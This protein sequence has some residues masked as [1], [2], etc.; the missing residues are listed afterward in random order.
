MQALLSPPLTLG[1]YRGLV[2]A[3]DPDALLV[4][5]RLLRRAAE[6]E[7]RFGRPHL[8]PREALLKLAS[9]TELGTDR[10]PE[11]ALLLPL[12]TEA[13]LRR[14]GRERVLAEA[15][16]ALVH[17]AVHRVFARLR[18]SPED[19]AERI[20]ALGA[21]PFA[22]AREVLRHDRRL[23]AGDDPS[24]YEEFAAVWTELHAFDP[25]RLARTF[26][27][28]DPAA[29]EAVLAQDFDGEALVAACRPSG[30]RALA[31]EEPAPL[32]EEEGQPDAEPE[33]AEE[34][35]DKG[36]MVRAALLRKAAGEEADLDE[37]AKRL[38]RHLGLP[39]SAGKAWRACF[40]DLLPPASLGYW[41]PEARLLYDLQSACLDLERPVYAVD[42][43]EALL[44]A[45]RRPVK[46]RLPDLPLA[47]AMGHL[48]RA[49]ERVPLARLPEPS[50]AALDGLLQQAI[51]AMEERIRTTLRP[52]VEAALRE[53][54]LAH[55]GKAEDLAW[56]RLLDELL[57]LVVDRG[58][59]GLPDLRDA[60]AR[61]RI[62]LPDLR[63][64]LEPLA[65]DPL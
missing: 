26:P 36:N 19:V 7:P 22:E 13:D 35:E 9:P 44:T 5:P 24:A 23:L 41:N 32:A 54:G 12:P 39:R 59:F 3:A 37:L 27:A 28:M 43:V 30:A 15:W 4:P 11:L 50:R 33:Q 10:V 25:E 31:R 29:A 40:A 63:S 49:R 45:F 62:G 20:E 18:L 8:V 61:S 38:L 1:E 17:G 56:D 46:R 58:W 48:R 2:T 14:N 65:G 57:D 60:I 47:T 52:K 16:A 42:V 55:E 6:A 21:M 53:A 51:R 34:A 64:P